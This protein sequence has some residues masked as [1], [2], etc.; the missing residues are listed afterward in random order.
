[1]S[2]SESNKN[3][4]TAES[5]YN[6]IPDWSGYCPDCPKC[7]ETMGYCYHKSEFKCPSCGYIMDEYDWERDDEKEN[8]IP[9]G[10]KVCGGPY[11]QCKTSCKLFDD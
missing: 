7:G 9:W 8:D 1:M 11:P 6:D 10:C 3:K 2:L 4:N 5:E